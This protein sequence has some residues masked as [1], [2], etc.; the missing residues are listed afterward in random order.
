MS[1][2]N[3]DDLFDYCFWSIGLSNK[4][5]TVQPFPVDGEWTLTAHPLL[6]NSRWSKLSSPL[7]RSHSW[8]RKNRSRTSLSFADVSQPAILMLPFHDFRDHQIYPSFQTF[9]KASCLF[10]WPPENWSPKEKR[11]PF[12]SF[13]NDLDMSS[14]SPRIASRPAM[15]PGPMS[16]Q[17]K[18]RCP[19]EQR[20]WFSDFSK[21]SVSFFCFSAFLAVLTTA[22]S[23][24]H[25][26]FVSC[27]NHSL[28]FIKNSRIK[29]LTL[30]HFWPVFSHVSGV[31]NHFVELNDDTSFIARQ[32]HMV[33]IEFVARRLATGSFLKRNPGV[34]EGYVFAPLKLETFFKV[35]F[36]LIPENMLRSESHQ[37]FFYH[38]SFYF[39]GK[40]PQRFKHGLYDEITFFETFCKNIDGICI[41]FVFPRT[42][43]ITIHN[44]P[45][46]RFCQRWIRRPGSLCSSMRPKKELSQS[47]ATCWVLC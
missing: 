1:L 44:G 22:Y 47:T 7:I 46:I 32:C 28:K 3:Q 12:A 33:P 35:S 31:K 25:G 14:S 4:R 34:P 43:P 2:I 20:R 40:L 36:L 30:P 9:Q 27:H 41:M 39:W 21:K 8:F 23:S 5:S 29:Y 13:L 19:T 38:M 45:T 16:W 15:A 26:E 10:Q 37:C 42:M 6:L 11:K 18:L 24:E 17:E